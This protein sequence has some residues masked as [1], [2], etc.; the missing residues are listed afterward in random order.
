[1]LAA[2]DRHEKEL[3]AFLIQRA[4]DPQL[5]EDLLQDVF[6]KA[7]AKDGAFCELRNPRAWLFRVARNRLID[8]LRSYK[9]LGELRPDFPANDEERAPL[10]SLT[11]CLPRA[12]SEMPEEDREAL[13]LCDLEGLP[14]AEYARRKGLSLP[15]AKSRLQRARRRLGEHLRQACQVRFDE[16]GQVCC[17]VPRKVDES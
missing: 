17:F 1:L 2:W 6:L 10:A 14:Q 9:A 4:G 3:R 7:L 11:S 16:S 13:T 5:A 8:H 12:L 15:G